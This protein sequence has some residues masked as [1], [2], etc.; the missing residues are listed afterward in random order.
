[1]IGTICSEI[2]DIHLIGFPGE[3]T[4]IPPADG[5]RG[6]G[7]PDFAAVGMWK[8]FFLLVVFLGAVSLA[9]LFGFGPPAD[10]AA[11]GDASKRALP[12]PGKKL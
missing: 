12:F 2:I 11:S 6:S 4:G 9:A 5:L 7:C 3:L 1:L 8:A 10:A